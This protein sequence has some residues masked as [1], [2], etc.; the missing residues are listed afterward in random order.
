[1]VIGENFIYLEL[2]KTGSTHLRKLFKN[3]FDVSI[4]GKHNSIFEVF[5]NTSNEVLKGKLILGSIRNPFTWYLSLWAYGCNSKGHLF[6]L[7]TKISRKNIFNLKLRELKN[8]QRVYSDVNN[9]IYF[10]RWLKMVMEFSEKNANNFTF[11]NISLD[12]NVGFMT[13]RF[14]DIY[15][16]FDNKD[17]FTDDNIK[18][19]NLNKRLVVNYFLSQ[20]NLVQDFKRLKKNNLFNLNRPLIID[21][22]F[23]NI[24]KKKKYDFYYND[25]SI[26]R[27][28]KLDSALLDTFKYK[29]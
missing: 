20:E 22:S 7:K 15:Y 29:F 24:T 11:N 28:S 2:H 9:P 25:E 21:Y 10:Q 4:I 23:S 27:V 17:N 6:N 8:W 3:N 18:I 1:M 16:D 26:E 12:K 5:G 13:K 14:L 19:D